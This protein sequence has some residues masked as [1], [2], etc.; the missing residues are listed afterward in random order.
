MGRTQA[1][2]GPTH[3][4]RKAV[5]VPEFPD[6]RGPHIDPLLHPFRIGEPGMAPMGGEYKPGPQETKL[7]GSMAVRT[8]SPPHAADRERPGASAVYIKPSD[9]S[10]P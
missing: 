6:G 2:A 10:A 8:I 9:G 4:L 1:Q 7:E 5:K 3:I